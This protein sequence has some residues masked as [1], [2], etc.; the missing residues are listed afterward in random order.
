LE[1]CSSS[2]LVNGTRQSDPFNISG[3]TFQHQKFSRMFS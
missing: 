1:G 2:T 3:L